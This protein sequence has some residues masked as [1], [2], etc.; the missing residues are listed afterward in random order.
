MSVADTLIHVD[1]NLDAMD[2]EKIVESI[3]KIPG[4]ISPKFNPGKEHMLL[5]AF[6]PEGT[7]SI[8]LLDNVKN[9]GYHAELVGL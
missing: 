4:V 1:E 2:R 5:V 6:D 7:K 8:D 9:L 3:R